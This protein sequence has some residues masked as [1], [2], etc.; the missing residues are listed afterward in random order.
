VGAVGGGQGR[1]AGDGRG[2]HGGAREPGGAADR[3]QRGAHRQVGEVGKGVKLR[4]KDSLQSKGG[5]RKCACLVEK[6][7]FDRLMGEAEG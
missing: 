1:H 7:V 5:G 6:E 3:A 2:G 4:K